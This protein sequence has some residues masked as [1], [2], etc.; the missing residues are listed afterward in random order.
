MINIHLYG[1]LAEKYGPKFKIEALTAIDAFRCLDVN[2]PNEFINDVRDGEF[3]IIRGNP[4]KDSAVDLEASELPIRMGSKDL[5]IIPMPVGSANRKGAIIK[6]VLGIAIVSFAFVGA[7]LAAGSIGALTAGF[8]AAAFTV[9]LIG[10]VTW[11]NIAMIGLS[12]LATGVMSL[13][14]PTPEINSQGY[15]S[16]NKD[17][18]PSYIFNGAVNVSNAGGPVPWVY[19]L[20]MIGSFVMS[21]GITIEDISKGNST[22]V[23]ATVEGWSY[24]NAL[25]GLFYVPGSK[26]KYNGFTWVRVNKYASPEAPEVLFTPGA[27]TTVPYWE[28]DS[29]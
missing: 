13:I 6:I 10:T 16:L 23:E 2:F 1:N 17:E 27:P 26:C 7:G 19:G 28:V 14:S 18:K 15:D 3:R 24:S 11:G 21:G 12:M 20:H 9:P 4:G 8:K 5:H 29:A 25:A 22:K